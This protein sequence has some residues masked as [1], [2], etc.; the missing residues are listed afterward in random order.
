M[1]MRISCHQAVLVLVSKNN[2]E[3]TPLW[4]KKNY[5]GLYQ[6]IEFKFIQIFGEYS[7]ILKF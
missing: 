4:F 7:L 3:N 5:I 2:K 6:E 1:G